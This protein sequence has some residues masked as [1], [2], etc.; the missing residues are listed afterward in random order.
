MEDRKKNSRF[1]FYFL[2]LPKV[3]VPCFFARLGRPL[4]ASVFAPKFKLSFITYVSLHIVKNTI[5]SFFLHVLLSSLFPLFFD[6]TKAHT[7]IPIPLSI[8][9]TV[10]MSFSHFSLSHSC[11]LTFLHPHTLTLSHSVARSY[12]QKKKK[13]NINC[14][15]NFE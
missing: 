5:A 13:K 14:R 2:T 11:I 3:R 15:S 4:F 10:F 1:L 7:G 9:R 6:T 8:S 12:P